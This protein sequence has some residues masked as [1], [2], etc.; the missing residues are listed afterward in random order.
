MQ[1]IFLDIETTGLDAMIHRPIDVAFQVVNITTGRKDGSYQS[2]VKQS[3]EVWEKADPVSLQVNGY[4]WEQTSLGKDPDTVGLEIVSLLTELKVARGSA[5]FICQNPAFDRGFFT[6]LVD[7]YTQERLNW[8]YHWLD[9][10]SMY[11]ALLVKKSL[12][13]GV[14]FPDRLNLSK[15]E[16]AKTFQIPEEERPHRAMK[17][18]DHLMTCYQALLGVK[19]QD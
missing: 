13:N 8:P 15:N 7:V 12:Q 5:V 17:G 10:A 16:I 6:Q 4:T 18:V 9:F 19:F 2:T 14:P 3:K 11:W 1:A